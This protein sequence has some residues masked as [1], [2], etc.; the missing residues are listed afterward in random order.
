MKT[1][2]KSKLKNKKFLGLV[3]IIVLVL[4]AL[5]WFYMRPDPP[6]PEQKTEVITQSTDAPD[7]KKPDDGYKWRGAPNDPKYIK[8][9]TIGAEGFIQNV[10]VDQN[11]QIAVPGNIHIAG[12]FVDSI[13]PGNT[14]LSIIDGHVDGKR[15]DGIFK[16]LA[17]LKQNDEYTV[18]MG[19]GSLRRY[20]VK[21][22]ISVDTKD[23]ANTLFSQEPNIRSQLNLITCGGNFDQQSQQY[24]MR[25]IAVSELLD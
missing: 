9:P 2:F 16:R 4:G 6:V 13:R 23:A 22:V 18:E 1:W 24:D 14:G 5:A 20:R 11:K 19:D 7:E 12:W 8:L 25:V 10:G 15:N 3:A 21:K 17:D